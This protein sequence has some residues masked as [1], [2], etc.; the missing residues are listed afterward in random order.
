MHD[1]GQNSGI[2]MTHYEDFSLRPHIVVLQVFNCLLHCDSLCFLE[3]LP[4]Y[5]A[6]GTRMLSSNLSTS[7]LCFPFVCSGLQSFESAMT[8]DG[9]NRE[10]Q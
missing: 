2:L 3:H 5:I 10:G 1:F 9:Y 7:L 6:L 8:R 4:L